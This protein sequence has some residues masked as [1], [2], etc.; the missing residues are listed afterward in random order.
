[1]A[2]YKKMPYIYVLGEVMIDIHYIT[3]TSPL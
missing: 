2:I 1:M 3:V